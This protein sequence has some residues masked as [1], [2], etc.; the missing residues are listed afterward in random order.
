MA[1]RGWRHRAPGSVVREYRTETRAESLPPEIV[2]RIAALERQVIDQERAMQTVIQ[3][4]DALLQRQQAIERA[5][6][7]LAEAAEKK[8]SAA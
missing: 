1:V 8:L 2:A 6:L 3:A 4:A 5:M 7:D